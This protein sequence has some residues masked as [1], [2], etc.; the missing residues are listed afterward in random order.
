M[1]SLEETIRENFRY[2][3]TDMLILKLLTEGDKYVYQITQ[4]LDQ[5]SKGTFKMSSVSLYVPLNRMSE[6]NFVEEYKMPI[7]G[8]RYRKYYRITATGLEY[9]N[10][11]EKE[12]KL[13]HRSTANI[14]RRG[15]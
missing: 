3:I 10:F 2:G 8:G 7:K 5:I 12:Y 11:M 9:L 1:A 15:K 6:R 13:I 14:M 4:E